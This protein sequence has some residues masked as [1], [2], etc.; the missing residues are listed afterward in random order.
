MPTRVFVDANV[1]FSRTQRDW[2]Y[3]LRQATGSSPPSVLPLYSVGT[4][5]QHGIHGHPEDRSCD[6][7][8]A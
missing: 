7:S 6:G 1:F 3:H 2:L 8:Q 4:T 5:C